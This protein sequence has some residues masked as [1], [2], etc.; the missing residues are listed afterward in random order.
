LLLGSMSA[1]GPLSMDMYLPGMPEMSVDLHAGQPAAQLT[2]TAFLF[3]L[4]AGQLI[5]GPASDARGRRRPLL[6]GLAGYAVTSALCAAAPSIWALIAL[7][8]FQGCAGATGVVIARAVVRDR[9]CGVEAA[10]Y[11]AVLMLV[12]GVAPIGAPVLGAALLRVTDWRGVFL[13]LAGVGLVLLAGAAAGL[14]ETLP[15]DRRR[16][17]GLR[18]TLRAF[19]DLLADR[20]FTG[21]VASTGLVFAG[22]F[23]YIAGSPFVLQGA[24]HASPQTFG[25][26]FGLNACGIVA[27]GQLSRAL[28]RRVGPLRLLGAG[29]CAAATGA[30]A[31]LLAVLAGAGLPVVLPAL[32][33]TIASAG[34]IAPNAT[35]LALAGHPSHAG[36]ASA[37]L[38][39][40]MFVIGGA[41]APLT[42]AAGAGTALPMAAIIACTDLTALLVFGAFVVAPGRRRVLPQSGRRHFRRT[43]TAEGSNGA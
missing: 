21:Y 10:R 17:G 7:R 25:L 38:G 33:V 39:T 3:G 1:F 16:P 32:F 5:A 24:Y 22:M 41:I 35:A 29:I 4:A 11:F 14:P 2:L 23:A 27:L 6:I 36:A 43:R 9:Y 8:L 18:S 12:S 31:L 26:V 13:V 15:P 19:R 37:L 20:R 34:M 28:V 40:T 30:A 42:G